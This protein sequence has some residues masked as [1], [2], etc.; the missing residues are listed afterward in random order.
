M[1]AFYQKFDK[2]LPSLL[3]SQLPGTTNFATLSRFNSTNHGTS[4]VQFRIQLFRGC[5]VQSHRGICFSASHV[6]LFPLLF[7]FLL[8]LWH[9]KNPAAFILVAIQHRIEGYAYIRPDI[10]K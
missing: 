1:A 3:L 4:W 10:F 5:L 2:S 8:S 6:L 7:F 9:L